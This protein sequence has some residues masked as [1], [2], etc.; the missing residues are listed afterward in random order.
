MPRHLLVVLGDQLNGDATLWRDADPALD[1]VW[2]CEAPQEATKVWSHPARIALFLS[3]MRHFAEDVRA[4]GFSVHY[5][6][7]GEHDAETLEAAL[8]ADIGSLRPQRVR[9]VEAGEYDVMAALSGAAARSGVPLDVLP[10]AH[11]LCSRDDFARWLAGRSQPRMEHFYRHMRRQTGW[12]M[13]ADGKPAGGRWNFDADNRESFGSEGP[14]ALPPVRGF[15]PDACTRETLAAVGERFAAHPGSLASF[16][17]PVTRAQA[18]DALEDFIDHRLPGFGRYQDAMWA[19]APWLFHARLSAA[20]NLK[21]LNPREVCEAAQAA[22]RAGDAPLAAVEGF[23]RQILGWREY[24][25]GLYWHGMPTYRDGNALQAGRGL[26]AFYWNAETGMACLHDA[27]ATTLQ[28]GY[29]HH[30]QRLMVTGLYA[31]LL[32][33]R[34]SEVHAW[35]LAVY[36]DAVE[37]VELPN[38]IGM[39]QWADGGYMASK[40]YVASGRY[41]QRMSN[42]CS[43]C[44][45]R[46]ELA[47]GA[48][49]CPVTTLYWDFLDRHEARFAEHPRMKMQINN[50]RRKSDEERAAIRAAAQAHRASPERY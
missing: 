42:Y 44:R 2:M 5:R 21:L 15:A 16:D 29:A 45:Y 4:R 19:G 9:M 36:V 47:T 32:G 50:L 40:P 13:T 35:Y 24:V 23:I 33:V 1:V 49:A 22:W 7:L 6:R 28:Y 30:I 46:P 41:I 27:I 37:W 31:L 8:A 26:P 18:L 39:S 14:P 38:V 17:W 34:P 20:L 43:T 11:F 25:R 12:L 10:D 48:R 3:A